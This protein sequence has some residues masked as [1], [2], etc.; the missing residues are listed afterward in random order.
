M[1]LE[2][3]TSQA[4]ALGLCINAAV[5]ISFPLFCV[6]VLVQASVI[7]L[8]AEE[9]VRWLCDCDLNPGVMPRF[10]KNHQKAFFDL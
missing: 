2:H 1:T 8:D 7:S 5:Y 9:S 4:L 6:L 3:I 10:Y